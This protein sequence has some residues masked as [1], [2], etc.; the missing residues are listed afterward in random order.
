MYVQSRN[1]IFYICLVLI[2]GL[3]VL[4]F[5]AGLYIILTSDFYNSSV[6]FLSFYLDDSYIIL[7]AYSIVLRVFISLL[8]YVKWI[9]N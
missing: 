5:I 6:I 7:N 9:G 3:F 8:Y 1:L 4:I 2:I